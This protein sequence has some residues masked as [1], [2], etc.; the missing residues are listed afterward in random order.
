MSFLC[1]LVSPQSKQSI[2]NQEIITLVSIQL[3]FQNIVRGPFRCNEIEE[4][5]S[6]SGTHFFHPVSLS[7]LYDERHPL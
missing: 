4:T 5:S 1:G 6:I 7:R 2:L 3:D